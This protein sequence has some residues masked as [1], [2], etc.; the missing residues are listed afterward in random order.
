MPRVRFGQVHVFNNLFAAPGNNYCVRAAR[1]ARLLVE[2]N[3]FEGVR[4]PRDRRPPRTRRPPSSRRATTCTRA[5]PARQQAAAG[6]RSRRPLR[7]HRRA[8]GQHGGTVRTCAGP[9]VIARGVK[10]RLGGP[11]GSVVAPQM[12]R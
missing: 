1:G 7:A 8:G 10:T 2:G 9:R 11:R 4:S 12:A 5:R 3:T 6:Q